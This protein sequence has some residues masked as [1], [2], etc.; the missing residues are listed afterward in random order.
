MLMPLLVTIHNIRIMFIMKLSR[1]LHSVYVKEFKILS[2]Q[3][4][5]KINVSR[6]EKNKK[7]QTLPTN[8]DKNVSQ[9]ATVWPLFTGQLP[10][11]E[12]K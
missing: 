4:K 3:Y 8:K 11:F 12:I 1:L 10:Y 2:K 7:K 9:N 5:L 6:G